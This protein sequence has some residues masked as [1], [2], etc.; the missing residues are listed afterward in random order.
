MKAGNKRRSRSGKEAGSSS[1]SSSKRAKAS[2]VT[3]G[4]GKRKRDNGGD[5]LESLLGA[6]TRKQKEDAAMRVDVD[7]HM[8]P[9]MDT[10]VRVKPAL[11][12]MWS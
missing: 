1:S 12:Q 8:T 7:K 3:S 5:A 6:R 11:A 2:D 10:G 4:A 9:R